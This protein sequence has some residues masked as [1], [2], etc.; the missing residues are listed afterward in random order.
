MH[1]QLLKFYR[2]TCIHCNSFRNFDRGLH[3]CFIFNNWYLYVAKE[4]KKKGDSFAE[5]LA[6]Q[7][8]RNLQV[9]VRNIHIRYEDFYTTPETPFAVG[10]TLDNLSFQV[11]YSVRPTVI[12]ALLHRFRVYFKARE[13]FS[14][15]NCE[16]NIYHRSYS[17][18]VYT[19]ISN[20]SY[21]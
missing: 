6:T 10:I 15:L 17:Y 13:L 2:I 5:K 9:K 8:V 20:Q 11:P 19:G 1:T 16:E 14:T 18:G 21:V 4:S 12:V 3:C 7:I